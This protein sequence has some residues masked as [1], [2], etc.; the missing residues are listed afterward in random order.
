MREKAWL[1][2]LAGALTAAQPP[3]AE[4]PRREPAFWN[5]PVVSP[6][7]LPDRRVIFRLRAPEARRVEVAGL[8]R[9]P[10]PMRRGGE[11]I[12]TLATEPLPPDL[13]EYAFVV[14]G[15]TIPDPANPRL[16]PAWRSARRSLVLVPG[17]IPWSPVPG[18]PRGAVARH[19]F[20]SRV[21]GDERDFYVYTPPDYD[22]RRRRP[23]PVLYLLHGL[24]D[25]ARAWIEVGAANVILD[26]LIRQGKAEPMIMVNPLGY[27]TAGGPADVDREEMLPGYVRVLLEEVMPRVERLYNASRRREDRAIAGLSMGGAEAVLAGLNHPDRFAWVGSFSGAFHLWWQTR[28]P[29]ARSAQPGPPTPERLRLV[30][31]ELPRVF[32][33]LDA[34]VNRQIRLLWLSCGTADALIRV[35][36]EF[37][38]YLDSIGVQAKYLEVPDA[39]HV[40]PLWR[41][42][43]AD[44]APLLFK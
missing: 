32:P 6:E 39:G 1:L 19:V 34:R 10:V 27:G 13:Y 36:R 43:F 35:N 44:F 38:A 7:V 4:A 20:H 9:K 29:E 21:A 31:A 28:P 23:Y 8:E 24:G 17:D 40:W 25:D 30:S 15:L 2:F 16:R 33:K 22:P 37:K 12:W 41:R 11:G 42:N 3:A 5:A 26:T 14:D 18:A